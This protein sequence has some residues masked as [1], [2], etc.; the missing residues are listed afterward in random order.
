MSEWKI[1]HVQ[2]FYGL[3]VM[4]QYLSSILAID[5]RDLK[6]VVSYCDTKQLG[7]GV[8]YMWESNN[9]KKI[10]RMFSILVHV[11]R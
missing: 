1:V 4:A 11:S 3:Y 7:R 2:L 9:L 6:D 8:N 10:V 5:K